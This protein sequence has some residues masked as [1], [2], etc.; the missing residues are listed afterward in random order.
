MRQKAMKIYFLCA[1][2]FL[3]TFLGVGQSGAVQL[4]RRAERYELGT[5]YNEITEAVFRLTGLNSKERERVA[6]RVCSKKP[7][8]LAVATAAADPF[9]VADKLVNGYAY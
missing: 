9:Q 7:I 5:S 4:S 3:S 6:I 8:I 1:A 2:L